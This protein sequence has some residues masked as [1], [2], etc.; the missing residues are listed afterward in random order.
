MQDGRTDRD[1]GRDAE[2][3]EDR[4]QRRARAEA[5]LL[6]IGI[7][8]DVDRRQLHG[9]RKS[10]QEDD[11]HKD[12]MWR[13]GRNRQRE[14]HEGQRPDIAVPQQHAAK[15]EAPEDDRRERLRRHGPT[16]REQGDRT[17]RESRQ[18]IAEL[19]HQGHEELHR[20]QS[21]TQADPA[22]DRRAKGLDAQQ[23]QIEDRTDHPRGVTQIEQSRRDPDGDDQQRN[24]QRQTRAP[25]S[26]EAED[27]A[28]Q[29]NA[30]EDPAFEIQPWP[31]RFAQIG[32]EHQRQ[33]D[34]DDTDRHID[35]K[36]PA[37]IVIGRD[38]AADQRPANRR[39]HRRNREIGHRRD[40]LVLLD[41]AQDQEPPDRRHHRSA[42]A[43]KH[44][45]DGKLRQAL[46]HAAKHGA[47]REDHNGGTENRARAEAVREIAA[48]G[49]KH[50][51]ADEIGRDREAEPNRLH[52]EG[53][54]HLGQRGRDDRR[55]QDVHEQPGGDD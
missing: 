31:L 10:V 47:D 49:Q 24:R 33:H 21:E 55:V 38:V 3:L 41:A 16:R 19:Q 30:G 53:P 45:R 12:D 5:A 23:R 32:N 52:A 14:N 28:D 11:E 13:R 22:H 17:R 15:A 29:G 51:D 42:D 6:D 54:R 40:E 2:L 27:Q 9:P 25:Q 43:L 18:P 36:D 20:A 44:A 1:S 39:D 48:D 8:D 26:L 35:E 46:R 37:P 7:G 34:T 50:R 4:H